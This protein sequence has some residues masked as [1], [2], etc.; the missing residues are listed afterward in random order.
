MFKS[1]KPQSIETYLEQIARELR[2][3]PSQARA[4]EMREIEAHLR[5]MIEQRGDVAAVLAQFGK[6]RK[7]GRDLRR[8]WE[9]KQPEAWWR[10]VLALSLGL[11]MWTA[12]NFAAREFF[13]AYLFDHGVDMYGVMAGTH[14]P[15]DINT[16]LISKVLFYLQISGVLTSFATGYAVGFISPKHRTIIVGSV[17]F[18]LISKRILTTLNSPS[19]IEMPDVLEFAIV[20]LFLS[21]GALLATRQSRKRDAKIAEAK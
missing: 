9:R 20:F 12:F 15:I 8:A 7:V 1:S 13:L 2:D 14:A 19:G 3:L 18:L 16:A 21:I 6:P 10:A 11:A 4:D 17:V 5:T